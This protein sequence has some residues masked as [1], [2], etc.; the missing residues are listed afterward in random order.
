MT[1]SN[2]TR[3]D[4]TLW[5]SGD[6]EFSREQLTTDHSE[7]ANYAALFLSGTSATPTTAAD[8]NTR[9]FY[10][11]K[12]NSKLYF[13]G[14]VS[15]VSPA[16]WT[17]IHPVLPNEHIH[18]NLQPLDADLTAVAALTD[19]GVMVRSADSTYVMRTLIHAGDGISIT[20][21][22]GVA[23]NMTISINST[24]ESTASTIAIRNASG[25][26]KVTEPTISTHV[27]TKNYVDTADALKANSADVYTK[28][29]IH[30]GKMYQYGNITAG[31]SDTS[32]T[33]LPTSGTRTTPRIYVQA[34]DPSAASGYVGITGDIWFAI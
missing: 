13:R 25:T 30:S 2:T 8:T 16:A 15:G 22:N 18:S 29:N 14:D 24:S 5:S 20:N 34:N 21:G 4:L 27:A 26:F 6:D 33:Q 9:A 17:Q 7:I 19:T 28:T 12:T 10:W 1:I 11:D 32:G 23:G 31:G 3:F